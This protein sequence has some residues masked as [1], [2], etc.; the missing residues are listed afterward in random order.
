ME[1]LGGEIFS[2][3]LLEDF[4]YGDDDPDKLRQSFDIPKIF[5]TLKSWTSKEWVNLLTKYVIC[6][7]C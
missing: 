3:F 1:E 7:L 2:G 6:H 5:G 4:V